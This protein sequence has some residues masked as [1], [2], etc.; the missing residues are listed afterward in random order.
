VISVPVAS[1]NI[2]AKIKTQKLQKKKK[3]WFKLVPEHCHM[4]VNR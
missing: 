2:I 1:T 4:K 3:T